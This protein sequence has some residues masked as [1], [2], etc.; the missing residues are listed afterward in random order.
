MNL[1][2]AMHGHPVSAKEAL[3][4]LR[5]HQVEALIQDGELMVLDEASSYDAET[6][7]H[8]WARTW[9]RCEMNSRS[10]LNFLGY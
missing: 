1:E 3:S 6:E 8:Q 2:D 9:V 10:I 4:E 5:A 7:T